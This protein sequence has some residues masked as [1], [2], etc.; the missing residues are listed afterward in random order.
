MPAVVACRKRGEKVAGRLI[1]EFGLPTS[2]TRV[3]H[4]LARLTHSDR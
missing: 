1:R 2:I 3:E 4:R